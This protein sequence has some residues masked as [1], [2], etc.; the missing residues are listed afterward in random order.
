MSTAQGSLATATATATL[1]PSQSSVLASD[2]KLSQST[3][4]KT[5]K[6]T[7]SRPKK[8]NEFND[9]RKNHITHGAKVGK[10][11]SNKAGVQTMTIQPLRVDYCRSYH[12]IL[13][14]M[15]KEELALSILI[16]EMDSLFTS[17]TLR[18]LK[19]MNTRYL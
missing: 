10:T 9:G 2:N 7:E 17:F 18:I 11:G 5:T 1:V 12:F 3:T 8:V 19:R 6:T 16:S 4:T 15:V 14:V 13:K